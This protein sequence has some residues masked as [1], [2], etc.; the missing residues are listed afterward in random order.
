MTAEIYTKDYDGSFPE[1][2]Q[3]TQVKL[4]GRDREAPLATVSSALL[5]M[6]FQD[7]QADL[8]RITEERRT[9]DT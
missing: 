8:A 2:G 3:L 4:W 7:I 5:Q 9:Q 1:E 6:L